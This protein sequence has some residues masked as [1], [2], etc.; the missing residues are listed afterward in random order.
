MSNV[1]TAVSKS[2]SRR[3]TK[4][5]Y[6]VV[7]SGNYAQ[8]SN[9]LGGETLDLTTA[10]NQNV[11]GNTIGG[12]YDPSQV[13]RLNYVATVDRCPVGLSATVNV[14]PTATSWA[15]ALQLM[16]LTPGT[17]AELAD[18]AIPASA[19]ADYLLVSVEGPSRMF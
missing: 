11:T 8:A 16:L 17:D 13:S 3:R 19:T 1:T 15:N 6:E 9:N 5:T 2:E 18:G 14:N 12:L 7:L 4:R 10:A